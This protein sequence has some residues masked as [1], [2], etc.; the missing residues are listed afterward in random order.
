MR[1]R[2][3][4]DMVDL[5]STYVFYGLTLVVGIVSIPIFYQTYGKA[6]YG[7]YLLSFGLATSLTFL[8]LGAGRSMLRYT[9]EYVVDRDVPKFTSRYATSLLFAIGSAGIAMLIF[10]GL[11]F[12][13]DLV[14]NLESVAPRVARDLFLLA[15]VRACVYFLADVS[16]NV[17]NSLG[18]FKI[19]SFYQGLWLSSRVGL[20]ALIYFYAVDIRVVA[21]LEIGIALGS[22]GI[23]VLLL[24]RQQVAWPPVQEIF[25][26]R[27][28]TDS[29]QYTYGKSLVKI[30]LLNY[31]SQN[32]DKLIIS[33]FLGVSYVAIYEVIRKPYS[34]L[35][36]L[37]AK[38]YV[39]FNPIF[40][41]VDAEFD[42][43]TLLQSTNLATRFLTATTV[44]II[45]S[46][47][48]AMPVILDFWVDEPEIQS[49][50]IYAQLFLATLL[51]RALHSPLYRA[52]IST[53][54]T[55]PIFRMELVLVLL[56]VVVSIGLIQALGLGSVILG[57][58]LQVVFA[59]PLLYFLSKPFRAGTAIRLPDRNSLLMSMAL[60]GIAAIAMWLVS[61]DGHYLGSSM[62][63]IG[64]LVLSII[65]I[66]AIGLRTVY[67]PMRS[68]RAKL[69][70]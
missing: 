58:A 24:K 65:L 14:F 70:H 27:G 16:V 28:L 45:T 51:T 6:V 64:T 12:F 52:M 8:D 56:N 53:G 42:R 50:T 5:A 55:R 57:T 49:Y 38:V 2:L 1:I 3:G 10:A 9:A 30:G 47:V 44:A 62:A 20:V 11:A 29:E 15:A 18:L 67:V 46:C 33:S 54:A 19:R 69:K 41:K 36:S 26:T 60:V 13:G 37:L 31:F 59:L 23:D 21:I 40:V 43:K 48:V 63:T 35:K 61:P 68:I 17:T 32:A 39:V 25:N 22:W 4:R 34:V 7:A 66:Q